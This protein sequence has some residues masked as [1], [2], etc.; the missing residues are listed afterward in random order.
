MN[1]NQPR[2]VKSGIGFNESP[3]RERG[4]VI[5][6][7]DEDSS[8]YLCIIHSVR[9]HLHNI[10]RKASLGAN[11]NIAK[12]IEIMPKVENQRVEEMLW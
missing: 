7:S 4:F 12:E 6:G 1:Q 3:K 11:D 5:N 2:M 10:K 8:K 9:D